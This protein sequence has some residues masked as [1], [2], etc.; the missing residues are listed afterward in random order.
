MHVISPSCYTAI[1]TSFDNVPLSLTHC[2]QRR[3]YATS[4]GGRSIHYIFPD[5][6]MAMGAAPR[7]LPPGY[8]R[9]GGPPY[10]GRGG[11][12]GSPVGGLVNIA[13]NLLLQLPFSRWV[14]VGW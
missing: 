9:G 8:G 1:L 3:P 12:R 6:G 2:L 4:R 10:Y 13:T 14:G 5:E 11:Q 7:G